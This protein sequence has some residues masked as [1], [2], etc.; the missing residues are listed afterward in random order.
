MNLKAKSDFNST[1]FKSRI[2]NSLSK[3]S[4]SFLRS[5]ER[6]VEW[7]LLNYTPIDSWDLKDSLTKVNLDESTTVFIFDSEYAADVEYWKGAP[8]NYH[9]SDWSVN[10]SI[11]ARMVTKTVDDWKDLINKVKIWV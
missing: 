10:S 1:D 6:V 7:R 9:Y 3:E 2:T 11:W 5:L 4:S 8:F